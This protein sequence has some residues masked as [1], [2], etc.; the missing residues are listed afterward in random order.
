[1]KRE[2]MT[3]KLLILGLD[4]MDPDLTRDHLQR[5]IMPNLE[6]F[7]RRGAARE[8]LHMLGSHPTI[9][10]PMW[11]TLCTGAQP[12]THGITDFWRQDPEKLDTYGY[13]LDSALC[14]A[15][16]LWNVT[17]EAGLKTL[18][19]HWPGSSWPPTSD[20]PNLM[21]VDGTNPEGINMGNA[22]IENE[23]EMDCSETVEKVSFRSGATDAEMMC[24]VTGLEDKN[25]ADTEA[26]GSDM[27]FQACGEDIRIIMP[28]IK[29]PPEMNV[30]GFA[31]NKGLA[32]IKEATGWTMELPE[33]A[34]ET[35]VLYSLGLIRR[36]ALI[37]KN[38]KGVCDSLA[39]YKNKKSTEPIVV[40]K[41]GVFTPQVIDEAMKGDKMY[42]VSRNMKLISMAEDGSS[43]R[44]WI[45]AALDITDNRVWYP[46]DLFAEVTSQVGYPHP[47]SNTGNM[48]AELMKCMQD[49]WM[50]TCKWYGDAINLLIQSH[51]VDVVFSHMHSIDAQQHMFIDCCKEN[52]PGPLS[53]EFYNECFEN[54]SKQADYYLGRFMHLLDE[55]WTILL[56]SDHG[57]T[58]AAIEGNPLAA[59]G[60]E[61]AYMTEWGFTA[62][63]KDENGNT[64]L[65]IDWE[66]TKAV[67]TRFNEIYINLKGRW[68]TGIVEPE[69]KW[70]LEEE[71]MTRLYSM[72]NKNSGRRLVSL[73]LRSKD[74]VL[75]GM[76]GPECGDIIFFVA[77]DYTAHHGGGL[78]TVIGPCNMSQ[79]PIF[80]AAGTGIKE[81]YVTER[82]I[83]ETDVA[84][85][86]AALLGVRMPAQCEGAPVY[87]IF[88]EEY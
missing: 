82:Q 20:S 42:S 83:H 7:I 29:N 43:L 64:L 88:A 39:I 45:S 65:D 24:V 60:I 1:M 47:V 26:K 15:E 18:V 48:D 50:E 9:T 46:K 17:A 61:T 86:A 6:E 53:R 11:T 2:A 41:L 78:S 12:Y 8:D 71:I 70:D 3:K 84:A 27:I 87:Q 14:H 16:Q 36:P 62:L 10:P 34:K 57:L 32:P 23:Y 33:G 35:S 19:F 44:I 73:A 81:N 80:V 22:Q 76:G 37:L 40:L 52:G 49:N 67:Q 5:G 4:G 25:N 56:V 69:D 74:A 72:T 21:V 79:S 51:D 85:T 38:E 55:G 31:L 59:V 54:L 63:K 28:P 77:D 30:G 13:A 68:A 75:L 66:H 58:T